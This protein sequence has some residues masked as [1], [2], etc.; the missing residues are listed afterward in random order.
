M[1]DGPKLGLMGTL[2]RSKHR[3]VAASLLFSIAVGLTIISVIPLLF[4]FWRCGSLYCADGRNWVW[5][6]VLGAFLS[7]FI[8]LPIAILVSA[9]AFYSCDTKLSVLADFT[10]LTASGQRIAPPDLRP[11]T[12]MRKVL[13]AAGVGWLILL[14]V[15]ISWIAQFVYRMNNVCGLGDHIILSDADAIKQAQMRLFRARYGSHGISGYVDE[16]P[17]TADF[18]GADCCSVARTRT[19]TGIIVWEVGL[20]GQ[21]VGEL[22]PRHVSAM[23]RLSNCGEVFDEDSYVFAEPIR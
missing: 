23:M 11:R 8:M 14:A 20:E 2:A 3:R 7:H 17:G 1:V 22:K 10:G 12:P 18:S 13:R 9:Y 19:I 16:K 5:T 15:W 21:T 4:A 6:V